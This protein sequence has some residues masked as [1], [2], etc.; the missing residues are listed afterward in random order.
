MPTAWKLALKRAGGPVDAEAEPLGHRQHPDPDVL[1]DT[2]LAVE[3]VGHRRPRDSP[4][5]RAMW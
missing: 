3:G 1:G 2:G 5:S 4:T